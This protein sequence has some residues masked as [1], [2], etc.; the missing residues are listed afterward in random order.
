MRLTPLHATLILL[1][2]SGQV[3]AQN[4]PEPPQPAEKIFDVAER[5]EAHFAKVGTGRGTGFKQY[6]RWL[7]FVAPRTTSSGDFVNITALTFL[8]HNEEA[9]SDEFRE[10]RSVALAAGIGTGNWRPIG[11]ARAAL[12]AEGGDIGRINAIA[13]DPRHPGTL[14]AATPASGLWT[15]PDDG[16]TWKSLTDGL[17][18]IGVQDIAVDPRSPDTIYIMTGD[19][20][21]RTS[22]SMGMMKSV[23][24]GKK[25]LNTGFI[26]K[27]NEGPFYGFRL[28]IHPDN[29]SILLAATNF[30]LVRITDGGK[31]WSQVIK[32]AVFYDVLFHPANPSTVYAASNKAVYRSNESGQSWTQFTQGLPNNPGSDRIR[33]A[34]TRASPDTLYVL[35]GA[36]DG[37][38]LGLYRSDDGGNTFGRQSSSVPK[39]KDPYNNPPMMDPSRP[40][41]LGHLHNDFT[42]QTWYDLMAVSPTNV[43]HIH[44][45]AV[46][47]WRSDD[48]GRTWKRT[49][50]WDHFYQR[51]Y[52]HSDIHA[53][54]FR[55]NTL[56]VGSDGGIFRTPD[57]GETWTN[58]TNVSTGI[59]I[60]QIYHICVTP[61]DANLVYFGAQD[62]GSWRL[63]ADGQTK[64]VRGGDGFVC[65]INPQDSKF[66]YA[67]S[68]YGTIY[69]SDDGGPQRWE[70]ITP[71]AAGVAVQ[72]PWLTPFVLAPNDPSILYACYAD[73]W[74]GTPSQ[75]AAP[76]T[77]L[78]AGTPSVQWTNLSNGALG[79]SVNCRQVAVAKSEPNTI[80]VAKSGGAV[81]GW[82]TFDRTPFFGGGGVYRS[83]DGGRTWQCITAALPITKAM[84]SNL[85]V[86]PSDSRRV[87]VTFGGHEPEIK[88]FETKDGGSTWSNISPGL[89]NVPA[90]TVVAHNMPA[91]CIFVGNDSGVVT[92][93]TIWVDGCHSRTTCPA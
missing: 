9:R 6:S 77:T 88:V 73:L 2:I 29:P 82:Q 25:W 14:Y 66:V 28:A 93:T 11:P 57:R 74:R 42:S 22:L 47:T 67:S 87:W 62:N 49:S 38:S 4:F 35:Y 7:D 24:G 17:G 1:F 41:I 45:G 37:F 8:R 48:G 27:A 83:T 59:G 18:L 44:V 65:Q 71:K 91:H 31:A 40:N 34:V 85:A 46:D 15:S 60:V 26:W 76:G 50:K 64:K 20:E 13:F 53:L 19:A 61:Q 63:L 51:D 21:M 70:I 80:Y 10:A 55:G 3:A 72:G 43:D 92:G 75:Q 39:P 81:A 54:E 52:V 58:I 23:D 30:G 33:L 78:P 84:I 32:G 68:Q 16:T 56:Y 69:Q 79:S 89:P 36:P 90:N 12:A 86:S 5:Y